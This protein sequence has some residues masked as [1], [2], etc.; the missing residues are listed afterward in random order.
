MIQNYFKTAWRN[1]LR[2]KV[3]STINILGLSLGLACTLLIMLFIKDELTYDRFLNNTQNIYHVISTATFGGETRGN[4]NTGILQGPQF[5]ANV[6]GLTDFVRIQG[7][8][9][10][11]KSGEEI[12]D[13]PALSVDASFFNVLSYPLIAGDSKSCL[14][15]PL[16]VVITEKL[17]LKVFGTTNAEG[18]FLMLKGDS[19]FEPHKVTAVAKDV[20]KNASIKFDLLLPIKVSAADAAN[21][22]S[23]FNFWL[24]TFV[25]AKPGANLAAI[26]KRMNDF[27]NADSREAYLQMKEK[28][29]IK[30]DDITKYSLQS[31]QQLHLSEIAPAQNGLSGASKS[32]YSYILGGIA[33]FI[34]L[35][36]CI[37]FINLSLAQSM[38]RAK[39][40]GIRKVMGGERKQLIGQFLGESFLLS[41]I[42]FI[43]ALMIAWL[44]LPLFNKLSDKDLAFGYLFDVKLLMAF[45]LL[46]I[47]TS[48]VA[49]F[50]PALIL[51][52]FAP[53]KTLYNR[54]RF[55]GKIGLQ[56]FL[57]VLQFSLA[58]F[59][60][61]GTLILYH[62]F[63][64]MSRYD[65]GMNN[66]NVLTVNNFGVNSNRYNYFRNRLLQNPSIEDVTVSNAGYMATM[67]KLPNDSTFQI[68]YERISNNYLNF[69]NLKLLQGRDFSQGAISDSVT[70]VIVNEAMVKK[71]GWKSPL[72]QTFKLGTDLQKSLTVIGVVKDYH[73]GSLFDAVE[74]MT[75]TM[76]SSYSIADMHIRLRTGQNIPATQYVEKTF[77]Q[78][79]PGTPYHFTYRDDAILQSYGTE[80]RWRKIMLTAAFITLFISAIGLF[81]MALLSAEKRTKEIGVRKVLGASV[82]ELSM[83]LTRQFLWL[84]IIAMFIAF[85]V[86]YILGNKWLQ[87]YAYRINI[88]WVLFVIAAFITIFIAIL[89]VGVQ[90]VKA[91]LANPVKSLRTE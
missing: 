47:F 82:S 3:N 87:H 20:P 52:G 70:P 9:R 71:C 23:W 56:K 68:A 55:S 24:N 11:I 77:K 62:Q 78:V 16:S 80:D 4:A 7:D 58:S 38:K 28:Y 14:S 89:T 42:A 74:P 39:E 51:S 13:Q 85:P 6:P 88:S 91:A 90:A 19:A 35:I 5:T 64:F 45:V 31:L 29:G 84:I 37:N 30:D 26:E 50:Y 81:G 43:V 86:A 49:G 17:A 66:K 10:I 67:A 75:L 48:L 69:F 54:F 34:L 57:V 21:K 15:D 25:V 27:Y 33:L 63:R 44:A 59:L 1:I 8:G 73:G 83:L 65:L 32:S 72:G 2:R 76:N 53:V 12:F 79:F 22:A 60:I 61:V 40:I 36:A 41:F 46:L 18:K